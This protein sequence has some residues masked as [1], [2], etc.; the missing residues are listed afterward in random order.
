MRAVM[1]VLTFMTLLSDYLR[2]RQ[3]LWRKLK[4]KRKNKDPQLS[5]TAIDGTA[6]VSDTH[7]VDIPLVSL[8][9]PSVNIQFSEIDDQV[10]AKLF[11]V[12]I[13]LSGQFHS[14]FDDFARH[15]EVKISSINDKISHVMSFTSIVDDVNLVSNNDQV[16]SARKSLTILFQCPPPP[17]LPHSHAF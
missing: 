8:D 7:S 12:K 13:E 14:F 15:L 17:T 1:G 11:E 6:V 16:L 4:Y 10:N 9:A 3:S 5:D 2:R